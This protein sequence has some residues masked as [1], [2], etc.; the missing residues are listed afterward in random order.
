MATNGQSSNELLQGRVPAT[1]P[2]QYNARSFYFGNRGTVLQESDD[3]FKPFL[4]LAAAPIL[5]HS[6]NCV[7]EG[8]QGDESAI[9]GELQFSR[10]MM[11]HVSE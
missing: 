10:V 9:G 1:T 5:D 3:R 6:L 7:V 2:N 4:P 11:Q 8:V